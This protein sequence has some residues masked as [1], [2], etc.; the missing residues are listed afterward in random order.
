M[1][2]FENASFTVDCLTV[3]LLE[4]STEGSDSPTTSISSSMSQLPSSSGL[5]SHLLS[6][7][8]LTSHLLSSSGLTSQLLSS[9]VVTQHVTGSDSS[10]VDEPSS[11]NIL[12]QGDA[13][14][15]ELIFLLICILASF[16][17]SFLLFFSNLSASFFRSSSSGIGSPLHV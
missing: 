7:S 9:S 10:S 8:G 3:Q 11:G 2:V 12:S 17:S 14:E 1:S 15:L 13:R 5:T 4:L 6:S 16:S